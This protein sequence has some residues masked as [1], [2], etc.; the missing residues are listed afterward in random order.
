MHGLVTSPRGPGS[1]RKR[2]AWTEWHIALGQ[3]LYVHGVAQERVD[4]EGRQ[5]VIAEGGPHDLFLIS[6]RPKRSLAR[7]L[8]WRA[9]LWLG[10]GA[11]FVAGICAYLAGWM[12][13]WL[14]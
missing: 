12:D 4:L 2:L 8:R 6:D 5:L 9:G 11:A 13:P 1:F 3:P 14:K 10:G 7:R